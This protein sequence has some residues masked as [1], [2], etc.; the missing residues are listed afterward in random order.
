[1]DLDPQDRLLDAPGRREDPAAGHHHVVCTAAQ[2]GLCAL[3]VAA[4]PFEEALARVKRATMTAYKHAYHN[5]FD[6][7]DLVERVSREQAAAIDIACFFNNR[8]GDTPAP[9][10]AVP[11][12]EEARKLQADSVF[13]GTVTSQKPMRRTFARVEPDVG[14]AMRLTVQ[15]DTGVLSPADG[16][17]WLRGIET[18]ALE[19]ASRT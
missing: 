9:A 8:R 15:L 3:D 13:R 5:P 19:A 16:E 6:L 12:L 11:A 14:D 7:E 17:A 18:L 1:V 2:S 10:T 4:V